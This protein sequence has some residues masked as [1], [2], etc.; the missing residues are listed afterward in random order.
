MIAQFVAGNQGC[1]A[2]VTKME[3][4]VNKLS[5]VSDTMQD[6]INYATAKLTQSSDIIDKYKNQVKFMFIFLNI[7]KYL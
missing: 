7:T 5:G 6:N 3:K 2:A 1:T 4:A